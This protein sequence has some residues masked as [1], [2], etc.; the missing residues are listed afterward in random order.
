MKRLFLLIFISLSAIFSAD[1]QD[2]DSLKMRAVELE[3]IHFLAS[4]PLQ[5]ELALVEKYSCLMQLGDSEQAAQTLNRIQ[6]YQL[7][8]SERIMVENAIADA[9]SAVNGGESGKKHKA[10]W[11]FIPPVGH[12]LAGEYG[13]GLLMSGLDAGVLAFGIWQ[14]LSGN[15]ITGYLVGAVG[16][17]IFYY[18]EAVRL[19]EDGNYKAY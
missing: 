6:L 16:L 13:R 3:R 1:C 12:F 4:D 17:E 5:A 10:I 18:D 9:S 15:W 14:I 7:P 8:E 2:A 19:L 11:A